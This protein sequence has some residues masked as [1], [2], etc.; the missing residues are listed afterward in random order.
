M[1]D[2][3]LVNKIISREHN[4]PLNKVAAVN[5]FYWKASRDKLINYE[6]TTIFYKHI[7]SI[8]ISK[9]KIY[10]EIGK[11]IRRIRKVRSTDKYGDDAKE[12]IIEQVKTKLRKLLYH[13]NNIAKD[14]YDKR[15]SES[16]NEGDERD[17]SD[18]ESIMDED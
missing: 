4:I 18:N 16:Y 15:I 9:Y 2:I 7:G 12:K 11:A 14:E 3:N 13:R 5:S 1:K 8:T 17:Q 10:K 6:V